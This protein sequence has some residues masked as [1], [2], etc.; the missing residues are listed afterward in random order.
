MQKPIVTEG[1]KIVLFDGV[2]N[3]CDSAVQMIIKNDKKDVFRFVAQQ[4]PK[5]QEIMRYLGIDALKTDS[6]ILYEPNVAYFIKAE[7]VM[8]IARDLSG[9]LHYIRLFSWLPNGLANLVYD[10]VAKNRY[11]WYGKKE[12]CMMPT[13]EIKQ[14]FL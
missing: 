1:K 2:C 6:I 4:E 7:A 12:S 8:E 13:P 14:K 5:G 10:F 11:Q 3:L 9:G